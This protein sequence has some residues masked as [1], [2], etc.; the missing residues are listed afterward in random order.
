MGKP[1][2]P[3]EAMHVREVPELLRGSLEWG[4]VEL[5]G[6]Q[7]KGCVGYYD[8]DSDD[9]KRAVVYLDHPV[10][11]GPYYLVSHLHLRQ[12]SPLLAQAWALRFDPVFEAKAVRQ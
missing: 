5:V 12:A 8:D 3:S 4:V 2:K 7:F 11:V 9:G 10:N 6:G 1:L